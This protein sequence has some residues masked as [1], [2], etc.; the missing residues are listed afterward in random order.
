MI[1][2]IDITYGLPGSGKTRYARSQTKGD[3]WHS[4]SNDTIEVDNY[5]YGYNHDTKETFLNTK[6]QLFEALGRDIEYYFSRR[7]GA[8]NQTLIIDGLFMTNDSLVEVIKFIKTL[9][10]FPKGVRFRILR[11]DADEETCLWN[12]KGRFDRFGKPK[13]ASITIKNGGLEKLNWEMIKSAHKNSEFIEMRV[14]KKP[15]IKNYVYPDGIDCVN[16]KLSSETWDTGGTWNDCWDNGGDVEPEEPASFTELLNV[17]EKCG[18]THLYDE[19]IDNI[20]IL[21]DDSE[22]DYYGGC[23]QYSWYEL[24]LETLENYLKERGFLRNLLISD[25]VGIED[26]DK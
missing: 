10:D 7:K 16:D 25:L 14:D 22:S 13:N 3:M 9:K 21:E 2:T 20:V 1:N 18:A 17:L 19:I 26:D 15:L 5:L 6:E 11:F 23:K 12:D 24:H 8:N 4:S